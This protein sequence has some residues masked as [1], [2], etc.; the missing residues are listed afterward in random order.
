[1]SGSKSGA[2]TKFRIF[3]VYVEIVYCCLLLDTQ[4]KN[5]SDGD[6]C[7]AALDELESRGLRMRKAQGKS[8]VG[9]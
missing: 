2:H 3:E 5:V 9:W 8:G 1:M 4:Y 6:K 7:R